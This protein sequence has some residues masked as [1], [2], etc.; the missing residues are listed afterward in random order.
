MSILCV[1]LPGREVLYGAAGADTPS[2]ITDPSS[3]IQLPILAALYA[4]FPTLYDPY[5]TG[6]PGDCKEPGAKNNPVAK[7]RLKIRNEAFVGG[8][9]LLGEAFQLV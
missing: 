6:K 1:T 7:G 4:R 8:I 9:L 5:Y 3:A 2:R